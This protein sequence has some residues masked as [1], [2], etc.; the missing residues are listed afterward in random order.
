MSSASGHS[1]GSRA[2]GAS[3]CHVAVT[4]HRRGRAHGVTRSAGARWPGLPR[5]SDRHDAWPSVVHMM[6]QEIPV[7]LVAV[8]LRG[9]T[10]QL[11]VNVPE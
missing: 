4:H 1:P 2:R 5:V 10:G 11:S 9:V 7:K 6:T 8:R 3:P